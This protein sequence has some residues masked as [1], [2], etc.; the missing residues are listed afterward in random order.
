[1]GELKIPSKVIFF[2][3][4]INRVSEEGVAQKRTM[5]DLKRREELKVKSF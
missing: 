3:N 4:G 1:M 2:F 5:K